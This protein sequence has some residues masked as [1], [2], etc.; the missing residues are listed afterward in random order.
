MLR[1]GAPLT[2]DAEGLVDAL[3]IDDSQE[4]RTSQFTRLQSKYPTLCRTKK[5]R[6]NAIIVLFWWK[7]YTCCTTTILVGPL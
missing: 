1:R 5:L 6:F 3:T 2:F 4:G 7:D